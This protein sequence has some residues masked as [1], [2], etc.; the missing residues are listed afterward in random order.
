MLSLISEIQL[1]F[2]LTSWAVLSFEIGNL[3]QDWPPVSNFSYSVC[4]LDTCEMWIFHTTNTT[5]HVCTI[6]IQF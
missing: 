5:L 1:L 6:Y 2:F 4:Q 3:K